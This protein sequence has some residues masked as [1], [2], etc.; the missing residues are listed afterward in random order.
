MNTPRHILADNFLL[1][2]RMYFDEIVLPSLA[3]AKQH[4]SRITK[5]YSIAEKT[6]TVHYYGTISEG[7]FP[8][9][10]SHHTAST[11]P[12]DLTIHAWDATTSD[13]SA[14]PWSEDRFQK[15]TLEEKDFFGVYLS[16]NE[17][18][19]NFYDATQNT[20]YFW[21]PDATKLP[22]W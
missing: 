5:T 3:V 10:L 11:L 15:N 7:V 20:G 17:S 14:T 8:K 6:V 22:D 9:A 13:I 21:V 18:S 1:V 16:G 4:T 19:L 12:P 2:S